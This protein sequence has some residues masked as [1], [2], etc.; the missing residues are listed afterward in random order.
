MNDRLGQQLGNYRLIRVLGQGGFADVYLGEHVYLKTQAALKVLQMRVAGE[1]TAGFFNE[2]RTIASLKHPHIVRVLDFGVERDI[3]YLVM[4]HAPLGTL[5]QRYP[6]GNQLPLT[7]IITYVK[8][9][10]SALQYAHE[11]R[12]V[13]R[14]VKPENILLE[15][16]SDILLS[17]FGIAL[18]AQSSRYQNTQETA[19]TIAYMAPEQL[20][21][22]PR[23]ASDQYA[24]GIVVYEWISGD[25]PFHGSFTEMFS[26]HLFVP[27]PPLYQKVPSLSHD[28]DS[29]IQTALAKDPQQRFPTVQ[30]FAEA[31]EQAIQ[32]SLPTVI[33]PPR[34]LQ[35]PGQSSLR[36]PVSGSS[37]DMTVK[38]EPRTFPRRA[39]LLGAT[40][41]VVAGGA[42]TWLALARNSSPG[43]ASINSSQTSPSTSHTPSPAI[44]RPIGY[45]F[46]TYQGHSASVGTVAWASDGQRIVSGSGDRTAQI[47]DANSGTT[48]VTFRGHTGPVQ[49]VAWSPDGKH[50]VSCGDD[51]TVQ[52]WDAASGNPIS[53]LIGHSDTVWEV[54]WSP[55]GNYIASA[56]NDKTVRVWD[57]HTAETIYTY[58]GHSDFV[59]TV[60][61]SSDSTRLVSGSNDQTVQVWE[62]RSG[63]QVYIYRKH[64]SLITTVDW[65]PDGTQIASGSRDKTVQIWNAA[66]GN[67]T[68]LYQRHVH[69]VNTALWSSDGKRIAS[70]SNDDTVHLWDAASGVNQ[71]IYSRHTG[72]VWSAAWSPDGRRVASASIDKTVQVWQAV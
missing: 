20:Q 10:A 46:L 48:L 11:R 65:S 59:Y 42:V 41:L 66:S 9:I 60:A 23:P 12:L 17:D 19:G 25:R 40:G 63:I 16:D 8:Q 64:T 49:S 61:W 45:L 28:I 33:V 3:P 53:N 44:S 51:R 14:D 38:A 4:D 2:A 52:I 26:Q 71:F 15:S 5:R 62:A 6:R 70:S 47:W 58:Q 50:V 43:T 13:H 29:V 24:L 37:I 18:V 68:V 57:V 27:P 34:G 39:L 1:D 32:K 30:A 69:Q 36:N 31:L 22:K 7:V 56:S 72:Y 67:T 21:G 55:D 35:Q 54:A